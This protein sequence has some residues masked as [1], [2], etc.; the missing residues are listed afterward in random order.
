MQAGTPLNLT[1]AFNGIGNTTCIHDGNV[2]P[3][4]KSPLTLAASANLNSADDNSQSGGWAHFV[5]VRF[6]DVCGYTTTA[7]YAYDIKRVS[8]QAQLLDCHSA[9]VFA[10]DVKR[11]VAEGKFDPDAGWKDGADNATIVTPPS[12]QGTSQ[13]ATSITPNA[14]RRAL[15][16]TSV[17]LTLGAVAMVALVAGF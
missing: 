6:K 12:A 10:Q 15:P 8:V 11:M 2:I 14:A 13:N 5:Q 17:L 4:C 3:N 7:T 16:A 1:W 9:W